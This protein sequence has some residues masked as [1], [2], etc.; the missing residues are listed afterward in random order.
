MRNESCMLTSMLIVVVLLSGCSPMLLIQNGPVVNSL[1]ANLQV[2]AEQQ[3]WWQLRFQLVW[4]EG[5]PLEFSRHALIAEQILAPIINKYDSTIGLWRFHRRANRDSAG[6][7]FSFIFYTDA[8]TAAEMNLQVLDNP[9]TKWLKQRALIESVHFVA[10]SG[11][12]P[13]RLEQTSD[14]HWPLAIQRSWPYFIMGVSQTWLVLVQE[15]SAQQKLSGEIG[16]SELL[17]HYKEVNQS[18][19]GLW[20]VHGQHAYLHHLNAIF[21][22]ESLKIKTNSWSSF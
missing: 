2:E 13:S 6:H 9:L 18:L 5:E 4:P 7:Q 3:G 8:S 14:Q 21:G 16:Y 15:L 19:T 22:Y 20:K 11:Q 17:N 10:V 1:P 12:N